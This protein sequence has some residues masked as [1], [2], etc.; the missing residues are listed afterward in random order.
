MKD[1]TLD[2]AMI[3]DCLEDIME[4]HF[5]IMR[6]VNTLRMEIAPDDVVPDLGEDEDD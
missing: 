4:G 1:L 3:A 2:R 5:Q 6:A